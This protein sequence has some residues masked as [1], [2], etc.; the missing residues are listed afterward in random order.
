MIANMTS[1]FISQRMQREQVY[2]A[3]AHQDGVHL[4]APEHETRQVRGRVAD[5]MR[6]LP[7]L[8]TPAHTA[9]EARAL[10]MAAKLDFVPVVSRGVLLGV[11]AVAKLEEMIA[12]G[13]PD[14]TMEASGL[15]TD[16]SDG[17][18]FAHLHADHSLS[19][20]LDRIGSAG[21]RSL[22]VV[23]RTDAR[24]LEGIAYAAD[25]LKSLGL[26]ETTR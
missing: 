17:P 20:A 14:V 16:G 8:P 19:R 12:A 7:E 22:P 15:L 13:Q 9:A 10:A 1:Y 5:A 26:K 21:T 2:E 4:P 23:S 6:P 24:R 18:S 3:L 25:L 11:V